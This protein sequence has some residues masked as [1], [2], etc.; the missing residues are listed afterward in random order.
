MY[1][2]GALDDS[3]AYEK[4]LENQNRYFGEEENE[5]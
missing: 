4:W 3:D 1:N 5:I 2:K